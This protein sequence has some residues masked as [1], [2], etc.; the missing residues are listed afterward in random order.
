M[1]KE[2]FMRAHPDNPTRMHQ[3]SDRHKHTRTRIS[4]AY[5]STLDNVLWWWADPT[6]RIHLHFRVVWTPGQRMTNSRFPPEEQRYGNVLFWLG[7]GRVQGVDIGAL[8]AGVV[9]LLKAGRS[10][11]FLRE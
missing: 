1:R 5:P 8:R 2:R 10:I 11:F 7:G 6:Y 9:F 4:F 3:R